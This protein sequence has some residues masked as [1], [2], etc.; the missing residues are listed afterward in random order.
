MMLEASRALKDSNNK[1]TNLIAVT[2]LT[3]LDNDDLKDIGFSDTSDALVLQ[4]AQLAKDS[5]LD[6]IVCSAKEI[7]LIREKIGNNFLLVVP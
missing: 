6:G 4:L 1:D 5:G 3:S 7:S 2:I